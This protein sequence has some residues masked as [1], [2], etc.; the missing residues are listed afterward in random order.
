MHRDDDNDHEDNGGDDED[1]GDE[2]H[3][4]DNDNDHENN[5][6]D[7]KDSNNDKPTT[8]LTSVPTLIHQSTYPPPHQQHSPYRSL[9]HTQQNP[10]SDKPQ[11]K[12]TKG[13]LEEEDRV[14]MEYY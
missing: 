12:T 2:D 14:G 3:D 13:A 1:N 6:N 9:P 5:N 8:T 7:D 10:A 11:P 4:N